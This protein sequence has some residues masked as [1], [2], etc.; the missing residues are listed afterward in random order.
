MPLSISSSPGSIGTLLLMFSSP[1]KGAAVSISL[2]PCPSK[3][4]ATCGPNW[5]NSFVARSCACC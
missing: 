5:S 4:P 3:I 2:S 1:A